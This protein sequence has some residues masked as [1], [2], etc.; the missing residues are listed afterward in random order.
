M[1]ANLEASHGLYFSQRVL[2]AL[3]EAGLPRDEAYRLVQEHALRAWDESLDF[4][5]LVE[6]DPRI[7]GRIDLVATFDL[8][9]YTRHVDAIFERLHALTTERE[10]THA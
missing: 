6:A 4:R 1:R 5:E 9:A 7:A 2:L 3:V 8:G 10:A